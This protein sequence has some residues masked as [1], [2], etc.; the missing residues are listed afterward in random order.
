MSSW[1]VWIIIILVLGVIA[2]NLAVLRYSAKFKLPQFGPETKPKAQAKTQDEDAENA[3]DAEGKE[4]AGS[5]DSLP[6]TDA[7]AKSAANETPDVA[8]ES[9]VTPTSA[10]PPASKSGPKTQ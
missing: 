7:S 5:P 8:D 9:T 6:D 10:K 4:D 3:V 2:S 1:E